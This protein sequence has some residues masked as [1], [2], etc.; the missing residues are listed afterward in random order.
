[1]VKAGFTEGIHFYQEERVV[2]FRTIFCNFD[3]YGKIVYTLWLLLV[4]IM[5]QTTSG[6]EAEGVNRIKS[7]TA[8]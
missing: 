4:K 5:T 6:K 2:T 3:N 1:M 7:T 8:Q